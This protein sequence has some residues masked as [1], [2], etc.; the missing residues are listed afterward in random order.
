MM[1]TGTKSMSVKDANLKLELAMGV[2]F[3]GCKHLTAIDL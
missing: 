1:T 2:T 3:V